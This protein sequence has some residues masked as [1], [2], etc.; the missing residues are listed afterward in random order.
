MREA[1]EV[2]R[3]VLD[4][5]PIDEAREA[6]V[7]HDGAE[8][9]VFLDAVRDEVARDELVIQLSKGQGVPLGPVLV[10]D[11]VREVDR[12]ETL[13]R[14]VLRDVREFRHYRPPSPKAIASSSAAI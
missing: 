1:P 2:P 9:L 12:R 6:R 14:E 7:V 13:R 5:L 11:P 10:D 3:P 8:P 4:R